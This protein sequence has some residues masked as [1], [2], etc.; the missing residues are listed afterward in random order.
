[1]KINIDFKRIINKPNYKIY[2][3]SLLYYIIIQLRYILLYLLIFIILYKVKKL[4]V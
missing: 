2:L 1:M 4:Y 3:F